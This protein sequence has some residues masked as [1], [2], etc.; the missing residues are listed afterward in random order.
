MDRDCL[1]RHALSEFRARMLAVDAK[2]DALNQSR[3]HA[4]LHAAALPMAGYWQQPA[5]E[6]QMTDYSA[7]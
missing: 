2:A 7:P 5:S 3:S 1:Y 4:T 6:T